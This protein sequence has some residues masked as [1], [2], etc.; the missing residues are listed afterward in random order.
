MTEDWQTI[1]V[2]NPSEQE[3]DQQDDDD[4]PEAAAAIISG[5]IERSA[6][7]AT[8]AAEQSDNENDQ[9]NSSDRHVT[10]PPNPAVAL[11]ALPSAG[12]TNWNK[13]SSCGFPR[14]LWLRPFLRKMWNYMRL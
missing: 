5:A 8:A 4:E 7:D 2:L 10:S 6:P 12:K 3:Q 13:E 9:D 14:H 11:V 1:S